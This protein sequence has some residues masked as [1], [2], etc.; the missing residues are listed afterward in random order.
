MCNAMKRK[1]KQSKAKQSNAKNIEAMQSNAKQSEA[2]ITP[3]NH[4]SRFYGELT[5]DEDG[6]YFLL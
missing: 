1:A 2:I 5:V 6:T 3:K 4:N